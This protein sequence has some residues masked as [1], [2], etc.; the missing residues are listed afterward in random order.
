MWGRV[1]FLYSILADSP[2]GSYLNFRKD[3]YPSPRHRVG[4]LTAAGKHWSS[5]SAAPPLRILR[6][7]LSERR[8]LVMMVSQLLARRKVLCGN[9]S[10]WAQTSRMG[11]L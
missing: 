9:P 10:L 4:L 5:P 2:S 7:L 8:P 1:A 6:Q 3:L 11:A